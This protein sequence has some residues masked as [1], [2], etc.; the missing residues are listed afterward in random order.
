M[1]TTGNRGIDVLDGAQHAEA[2]A[3]RQ[4]QIGQ[5]DGGMRCWRSAASASGWSRASTTGWPCDSSARRSIV[6]SESWSSTRRTTARR[7]RRPTAGTRA[8]RSQPAGTPA[9]RA[10]SSIAGDRLGLRR[11]SRAARV[12]V[13]R[14]ALARFCSMHGSLRRIVAV[15][16]VG[17]QRVDA[18]LQ[19]V[20]ERVG[21]LEAVARGGR[22]GPA[23]TPGRAP[24]PPARRP[25]PRRPR[26][27][28]A[29]ARGAVDASAAGA[30]AV[31]SRR[32]SA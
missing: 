21:A 11:R 3:G 15:H 28:A 18:G 20:G 27:G 5:D 4:P 24:P 29:G 2:V 10:S 14:R 19:R 12:R 1:T 23:S 30:T 8:Q 13:R 31:G 26:R 9:L 16:E 6:R 25:Q 7:R 22:C 32:R 17:R